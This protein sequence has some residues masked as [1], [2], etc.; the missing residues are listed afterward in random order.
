MFWTR[1]RL[2]KGKK[3][4]F[5]K[6]TLNIKKINIFLFKLRFSNETTT[7]SEV[8]SFFYRY[9]YDF[10]LRKSKR[11]SLELEAKKME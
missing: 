4:I 1:K 6:R 10:E 3:G 8:K 5:Q 2:W 7:A 9:E 11:A